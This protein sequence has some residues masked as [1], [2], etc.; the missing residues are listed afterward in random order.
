MQ[1]LGYELPRILPG[2]SVN[3]LRSLPFEAFLWGGGPICLIGHAAFLA[4][5]GET[6]KRGAENMIHREFIASWFTTG[7]SRAL[8]CNARR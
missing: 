1:H 7:M 2:T 5:L 8:L 4:R 6:S 3:R